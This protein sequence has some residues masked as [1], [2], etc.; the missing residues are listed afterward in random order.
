[1]ILLWLALSE[2]LLPPAFAQDF[3]PSLPPPPAPAGI[4]STNPNQPVRPPRPNAPDAEHVF[5]ESVTQEADGPIR[6]LRGMVR[7]ETTDMLMRADEVDYNA[8]T[9]AIQA[10]GHVYFES[11]QRGEKINCDRADYN[12]E[13]ETGKFYVVTGTSVP[14]IH[15]RPGLLTTT[16]PFYFEAQWAEKMQDRYILHD[17]F[18]TDCLLPRPW[19]RL[20]APVFDVIPGERAIA[21]HAWFYLVRFPLFYAP[22][23]YKSL[24]KEPR[25]SGI[26]IPSIGNSSTRGPELNYGYYWAINR[27]FDLLYQGQYY[28]KAGTAQHIDFRGDINATTSFNIRVDGVDDTRNLPLPA[29]GAEIAATA[30]TVLGHGWE[31]RGELNYLSSFSFV[32]YY[33]ESF[34]EAVFGETHSVGYIDK[35]FD[36]FALY[37]VAQQNVDFQSTTP[38]DVVTIH[39]LPEVQFQERDHEFHLGSQPFWVSFQSSA[40]FESRSQPLNPAI[41]LLQAAPLV[42]TGLFVPRADFAPEVNTAFHWKGINLV[43]SFGIRET[44]YGASVAPEGTFNGG[45]LWRNSREF[46]ADLLFP[47][48]ERI[49]KAPSWI[50]AQVKHVIE[51]RITYTD[52]AGIDNFQNIIRFD[53]TDIL[54]DTNQLEFS[55]TNRLLAKDKN[56][57]VTDFLSWQL[58]YERYFDPTF[59]GAVVP[60]ERNVV[61]AV[62]DLTGYS[63]LDGLRHSSPVVSALRMQQGRLTLDWRLDYD[64]LLHR[65]VN[66]STS[67]GWR[68]NQY[69]FNL[70]H[71]DLQ[72]PSILAPTADQISGSVGYGQANR[73]GWGAAIGTFYDLLKGTMVSAQ[74]QVTYNT[75]CCGASV[76]YLRVNEGIRDE[77]IYR[78]SFSI[79]NIGTFGSLNR[80]ERMF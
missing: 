16:N 18:L 50:G 67:V 55:L 9:G 76:Q 62:L 37:V 7:V 69:F 14:V 33:S 35:H 71:T 11:F 54:S 24:E 28:E 59:G 39:K 32:Q 2:I 64:P 66:S 19:W 57:T 65:I 17:G 20:R 41:S 53:G 34:N 6:H 40:G 63:F 56:G 48:L 79:S 52:V 74:L 4:V 38:G 72:A 44:G 13:S 75:D 49:F 77:S 1:M 73:R 68:V 22:V 61:Q 12:I 31:A 51:P 3:R 25:R 43:P 42:R 23:F 47:S 15:T 80:Q 10:R 58:A 21:H 46:K 29:S 5:I 60:G 70:G 36:D 8:D 26:I 45:S 78:F 27:S 30:K